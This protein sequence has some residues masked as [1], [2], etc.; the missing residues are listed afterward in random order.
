MACWGIVVHRLPG[1]G[2]RLGGTDAEGIQTGMDSSERDLVVHNI[3]NH[4][5]ISSQQ[6]RA[7]VKIYGK[8]GT[9]LEHQLREVVR[10]TEPHL[11]RALDHHF[12]FQQDWETSC[13]NARL[14][15]RGNE[16]PIATVC[17]PKLDEEHDLGK[18]TPQ[19]PRIRSDR[20]THRPVNMNFSQVSH[21]KRSLREW[22]RGE[23]R[24]CARTC[25]IMQH[26]MWE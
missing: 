2:W 12:K 16:S 26:S 4:A 24:R 6:R 9:L 17:K 20:T 19:A 14:T 1:I 25:T 15:A 11:G 8:S 23:E 5:T 7:R 10:M 21:H 13:T 18:S 22:V 3:C